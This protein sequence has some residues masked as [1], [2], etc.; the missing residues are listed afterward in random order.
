M[1]SAEHTG[2]IPEKIWRHSPLLRNNVGETVAIIIAKHKKFH[3]IPREWVHYPELSN[4]NGNTVAMFMAANDEISI[5]G[6]MW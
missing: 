1:L 6:K 5:L 2:T 4:D 3:Y